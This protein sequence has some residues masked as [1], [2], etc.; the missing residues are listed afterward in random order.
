MEVKQTITHT[1]TVFVSISDV[2]S[3]LQSESSLLFLISK[4]NQKKWKQQHWENQIRGGGGARK[5]E[6]KK[7]AESVVQTWNPGST[8]VQIFQIPS[9]DVEPVPLQGFG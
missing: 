8:E 4:R 9:P 7:K 3:S 2:H 1:H 6:R 5:K